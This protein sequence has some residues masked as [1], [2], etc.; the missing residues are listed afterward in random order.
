[1]NKL[2]LQF[3]HALTFRRAKHTVLS[4]EFMPDEGI[5]KKKPYLT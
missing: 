4:L 1:M 3:M 5:W 2:S